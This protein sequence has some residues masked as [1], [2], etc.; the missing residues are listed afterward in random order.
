M[1]VVSGFVLA[2]C[3]DLRR[4]FQINRLEDL[5]VSD[6]AWMV[7]FVHDLKDVYARL[8]PRV[9]PL[10]HREFPRTKLGVPRDGGT[11]KG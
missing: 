9:N 3:Q 6:Y 7:V 2:P 10:T 1:I 4:D 8:Q 11:Q 5:E